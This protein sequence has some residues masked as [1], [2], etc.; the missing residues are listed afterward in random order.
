MAARKLGVQDN[1]LCG[2]HGA[3]NTGGATG[4]EWAR[5]KK[6]ADQ[7][8]AGTFALFLSELGLL[9][10]RLSA[11]IYSRQQAWSDGACGCLTVSY[12]IKHGF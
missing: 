1:L 3:C 6:V 10:G 5:T 7:E 4:L 11:P 2:G 12:S 9:L 8:T